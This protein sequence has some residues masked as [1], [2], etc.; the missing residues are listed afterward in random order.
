MASK[1]GSLLV[2]LMRNTLISIAAIL[3]LLIVLV[4]G[5]YA[6]P[7]W[8]PTEVSQPVVDAVDSAVEQ[9]LPSES[10]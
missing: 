10:L 2:L 5:L 7:H 4:F 9:I 8:F 6:F 3:L 1:D